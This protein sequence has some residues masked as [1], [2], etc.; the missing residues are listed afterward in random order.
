MKTLLL[1]VTLTATA[2]AAPID[3]ILGGYEHVPTADEAR[4]VGPQALIDYAE[5]LRN[6]QARRIQAIA[7]LRYV[8][9][10]A[11]RTYAVDVLARLGKSVTGGAVL[12]VAAALTALAP[13]QRSELII[14]YATHPSADVRQSAA[15][16]LS[17]IADAP[18]LSVLRTRLIA[19]RDPGVR[20]FLLKVTSR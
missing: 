15:A 12:E 6:P 7:A 20:A 14:P 1:L 8:P 9:C 11:A 5:N 13:Y 18:S 16:S 17:L 2:Q 10:D 19:E 3:R 4:S